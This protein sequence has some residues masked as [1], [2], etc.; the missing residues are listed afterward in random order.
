[1]KTITLTA[2][3]T[4]CHEFLSRVGKTGEPILITKR[5]KPIAMLV[6]SP[7]DRDEKWTLGKHRHTAKVVG[8]VVSP[9]DEP[10]QAH[11]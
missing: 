1:M 2:F 3:K 7:A 11:R 4:H 9:L 10:W 8:D 5:G 6:P